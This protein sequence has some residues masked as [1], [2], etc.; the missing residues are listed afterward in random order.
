MNEVWKAIMTNYIKDY[1]AICT[2]HD[3]AIIDNEG[4]AKLQKRLLD[5]IIVTFKSEVQ[6]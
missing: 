2:L 4:A 3:D 5:E 1:E 6:E